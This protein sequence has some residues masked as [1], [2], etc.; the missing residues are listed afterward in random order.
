[1]RTA[2]G[3]DH[4]QLVVLTDQRELST[5]VVLHGDLAGTLAVYMCA[6]DDSP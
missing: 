2:V 4:K 1:M 3:S 5:L 6:H